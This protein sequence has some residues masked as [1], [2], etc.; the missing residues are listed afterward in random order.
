MRL[1]GIEI[2]KVKTEKQLIKE[3][4][5]KTRL[6]KTHALSDEFIGGNLNKINK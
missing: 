4:I 2:V 1:L 6:K 3:T 5:I